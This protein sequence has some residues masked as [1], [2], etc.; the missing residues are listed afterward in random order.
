[1]NVDVKWE[2]K[3]G[4][5]GT[6]TVTVDAES[7]NSALDQAFKKVVKKVNVPGFRKGKV[8]RM[9]FEQRFG[10]E[11]LYED[12]IDIVLPEAYSKAVDEAD[13][14]PVDRPQIDVEK[15]EKGSEFIFK[16]DVTVRPEV[17]LGEYKGLELVKH[18][19]DV[20][21]EEVNAELKQRQERFAE[22]SV[23]E[24]GTVEEGNTVVID[25]E[26]FVDGEPFE[27]GKAENYSL[28]V[29]SNSFIPGFEEQL[30]GMGIGE[31]KDVNVTFPEEY[32]AEELKGKP[33][34]FKVK[35]HEIK[36]KELP[37]L[38]DEFAKDVD[39]EVETLAELKE[40]IAK[41]LKDHKVEHAESHNRDAVVEQATNNAEI[42]LPAVM[43]T[44]ELD[45]ME[46]EFEQ[47]IQSQ[48]LTLDMYYQFSGTDKEG[49][50]EQMKADAEKRVRAN[51]TLDAIVKAENIEASEEEVNAEL[52]KMAEQYKMEVDQIKT[53]L[54]A[55][56]GT[57]VIKGDIKLRKAVDF[58]VENGVEGDKVHE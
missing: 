56:G 32:H 35:V 11:A 43:I 45:A 52:Q 58:L 28:E 12:A 7:F 23:K 20:T 33:A 14:S 54:A 21:E 55:Q 44:N 15:V 3:E 36:V 41:H 17:K 39:E 31:E 27:G 50:R 6:L 53:L 4:N 48:G 42:D 37:E 5:E 1:M 19:L 38:D 57:D 22:L 25:F 34:V 30:I 10:V 13:I 26:G 46:R 49:L 18:N 40:K 2:K 51:L 47:R 29:G 9:I 24:E 16:A 8:P